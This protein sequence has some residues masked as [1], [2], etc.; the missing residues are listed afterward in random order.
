M[1]ECTCDY[2]EAMV[3]STM[4]GMDKDKENIINY[5]GK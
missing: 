2:A 4:G 1:E 3:L 5:I